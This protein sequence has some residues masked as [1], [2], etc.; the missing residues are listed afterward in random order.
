MNGDKAITAT[1]TQ[2]EYT[3]SITS[4]HGTVAKNRTK[5]RITKEMWC[6]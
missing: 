2:N 6:N 1:F 4:A 3:L 5:E